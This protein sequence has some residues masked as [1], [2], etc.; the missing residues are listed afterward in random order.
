MKQLN[1][2]G[3]AGAAT[4]IQDAAALANWICALQS[5]KASDIEYCFKEY[6]VERYP[7]VK[8]AYEASKIFNHVGGKVHHSRRAHY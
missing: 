7:I 6:R 5:K 2:A 4:T 3:G 1:P 8:A